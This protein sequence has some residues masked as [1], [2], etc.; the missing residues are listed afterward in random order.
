[1]EITDETLKLA[2]IGIG[3][4]KN[5]K[6]YKAELYDKYPE[7][8]DA[9]LTLYGHLGHEKGAIITPYKNLNKQEKTQIIPFFKNNGTKRPAGYVIVPKDGP[10][11]V[12]YHGTK[13]GELSDGGTR[14]IYHDLQT[15]PTDM[16]FGKEK[17]PVHK[18]FKA[19]YEASKENLYQI[20][21]AID[22]PREVL[23]SGHSLG[24]AVATIATLDAA[25]NTKI[26]VGGLV[27]CGAPPAL[28]SGAA[29][30]YHQTGLSEKTF[31]MEQIFDPFPRLLKSKYEHVGKRIKLD[32]GSL[33]IHGSNV[34]NA[35]AK[36]ITDENMKEAKPSKAMRRAELLAGSDVDRD[37][38]RVSSLEGYYEAIKKLPKQIF[39]SAVKEVIR[40]RG[41]LSK[42]SVKPNSPPPERM[43]VSHASRSV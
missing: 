3:L 5:W 26:Q 1:M 27:T 9:E 36:K 4:S 19:E 33:K 14:E 25:T 20:L 16:Q 30:L 10:A 12:C 43:S 13:F 32:A 38:K 2:T 23:F 18:G 31:R 40:I 8:K 11:M 42:N 6:K 15:Q 41:V 37:I 21:N 29:N 34:Y 17:H 22:P 28:S 7:H 24:G 35:M 39:Y